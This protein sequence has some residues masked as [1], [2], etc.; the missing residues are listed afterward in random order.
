LFDDAKSNYFR[1]KIQT[2]FVEKNSIIFEGRANGKLLL[3]GEYAVLDGAKSLAMPTCFG[4]TLK[5]E[6]LVTNR[7]ILQKKIIWQS[8]DAEGKCWFSA[9]F[10][11]KDF[12]IFENTDEKIAVRLQQILQKTRDQNPVYLTNDTPI[13]VETQLDF[14]RDWGLGT[15]STLLSLL[16]DFAKIDPY[17]LLKNTFGGSGYDLACARAASPILFQLLDEKPKI[18][19]TLFFPIFHKSLYFIYLGKK[20][21]S[22]AGILRYQAKSENRQNLVE[23]ISNLTED[24]LAATDLKTFEEVI[25]EHENMIS[26]VVDLERAQSI[27]FQD[28]WGETKSLGAWGGDFVLATSDRSEVETCDYFLKKG[29]STVLSFEK[30]RL[31]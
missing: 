20:Q 28:F 14:P 7:P 10:G 8:L 31:I 13:F 6:H 15:S 3:T 5:I 17:S 9:N 26:K 12:E 29:F 30:M 23:K 22:R 27:F 19:N 24:F 2:F 25:V 4:Q 16:A 21:D 1:P 18:E 11:K